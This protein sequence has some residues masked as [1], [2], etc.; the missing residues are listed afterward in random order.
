MK[1][2]LPA[3]SEARQPRMLVRVNGL[4]VPAL[5]WQVDNNSYYAADT[6]RATFPISTLPAGLGTD[7]WFSQS[8]MEVEILIGFPANPDAPQ[9]GELMS[10]IYGRADEVALELNDTCIEI[11]GR[12]LTSVLIDTKTSQKFANLT[13]SQVATKLAGLHGLTPVVTATTKLVG[14]FYDKDHVRLQDQR[15]EWDLISFLAREEGFLVYIAGKQ[16]HFEPAPNETQNPYVFRWSGTVPLEANATHVKVSRNLTLAK[17]IKV[18][19]RSWNAKQ[20]KNFTATAQAVHT[21]NKVTRKLPI[22]VSG[23]A[24]QYSVNTLP[25]LTQEQ[26]QARANQLLKE[27]SLHEMRL[28]VD[29]PADNILTRT[30]VIQLQGTGTMADQ[31]YYPDSITRSFSADEG[32]SWRIEAK[33]HATESQVTL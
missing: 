19:V 15:S 2:T 12:D 9:A 1:N 4:M 16:L 21:R 29:G 13:A 25:G 32:Y 23:D 7:W 30:D 33:N 8:Q 6:F 22:A 31:V 17:D 11:L 27:I 18:T 3:V 26:V 14:K 10:L 24:Q 20:K 5:T 28:E